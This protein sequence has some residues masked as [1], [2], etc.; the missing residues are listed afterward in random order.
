MLTYRLPNGTHITADWPAYLRD[1]S[2]HGR[3]LPIIPA[4]VTH[5][6]KD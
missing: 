5:H 3:R 2:R 1:C 6:S 4:T